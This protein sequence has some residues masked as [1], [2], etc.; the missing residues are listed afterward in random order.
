MVVGNHTYV[1]PNKGAFLFCARFVPS[2]GEY[3]HLFKN[4]NRVAGLNKREFRQLMEFAT[5]EML[6]VF[7][8]SYYKQTEESPP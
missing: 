2:V 6:F 3:F 1:I 7:N 8:G 4:T 5:K